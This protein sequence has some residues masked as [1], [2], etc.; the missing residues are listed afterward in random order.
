M[1][2]Q[3]TVCYEQVSVIE[4]SDDT[5][6]LLCQDIKKLENRVEEASNGNTKLF[7]DLE[8]STSQVAQLKKDYELLWLNMDNMR[9]LHAEEL[10]KAE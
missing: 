8:T 2:Y 3:I 6:K 5:Y 1:K 4:E 7:I 9:K 10:L